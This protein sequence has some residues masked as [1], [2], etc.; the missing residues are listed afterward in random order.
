M[1]LKKG[2][3]F[4]NIIGYSV[5]MCVEIIDTTNSTSTKTVA[6]KS[7]PTIFLYF[8][9]LFINHHSIIDSC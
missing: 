1:K 2:K 8:T 4:G 6:A 9:N 3:Y 5:I 7:T